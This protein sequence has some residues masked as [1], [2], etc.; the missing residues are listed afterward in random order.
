MQIR[1]VTTKDI[2][3][4]ARAYVSSFAPVDP[5]EEWSEDRAVDLIKYFLRV[6]PDLAFLAD[7]DQEIAGGICGIIKPW[8]DG[9][10][11]VETEL[12]LRPEFQK[13]EVGTK[14]FLHLLKTAKDKYTA[15]YIESITFK[16][17]NFPG[18]WYKKLGFQ[19]KDDW[20]VMFGE[21]A[22]L[23]KSLE[24]SLIRK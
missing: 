4:L 7:V 8:W 21:V 22:H 9:N 6:Q 23:A 13:K 18:S 19:D 2:S 14:L 24:Q 1:L 16:D 20:K 10:H 3:S 12:F 15:N 17:L 5:S 11:L